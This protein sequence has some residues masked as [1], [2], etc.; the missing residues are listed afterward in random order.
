VPRSVQ[1]ELLNYIRNLEGDS[2][3]I[4]SLGKSSRHEIV[5]MNWQYFRFAAIDSIIA[6]INRPICLI[7]I[8]TTPFTIYL[9]RKYQHFKVLT[10]DSTDLLKRRCA[11]EGVEH[12]TIN[13]NEGKLPF[14]NDQADLIIFTEVLEH[15]F[16]QPSE[17]LNE[18]VR[19][20]QPTGKLI[21][22][23]PNFAC[24]KN[25]I[26]LLFGLTPLG[27]FDE[28]VRGDAHG[29]GHIHEYTR[30]EINQL[31][32][33]VGLKVIETK[34]LSNSPFDII[35]LRHGIIRFIYAAATMIYPGF[36]STIQ[37]VCEK[38]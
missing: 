16:V 27:N 8:G 13:L 17:L 25:R 4:K 24:L 7:D 21:I 36:R 30:S 23:V 38:G 10:V 11:K 35:R 20:L 6:K 34:M 3:N 26:K 37:L 33:S 32:K 12:F 22:S 19:V 5:Y 15:L 18:I 9:K 31:C 29:Y 2:D 14:G 28:I 1:S